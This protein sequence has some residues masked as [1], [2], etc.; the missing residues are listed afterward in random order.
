MATMTR[1]TAAAQA[2]RWMNG[3][4]RA[5][6]AEQA[7][8]RAEGLDPAR[9]IALSLEMIEAAWSVARSE[10]ARSRREREDAPVRELWRRARLAG[11]APATRT[12][13]RR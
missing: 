11:R 4:V 13:G 10:A 1:A 12:S 5:A 3:H 2:R 9:A 8:K 6:P 7:L